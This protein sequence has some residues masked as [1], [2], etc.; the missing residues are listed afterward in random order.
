MADSACSGGDSPSTSPVQAT[1]S[2]RAG[3]RPR[4][5]AS[6][7]PHRLA[8]PASRRSFTPR[9]CVDPLV[10]LPCLI[11]PS[12]RALGT[13][14]IH[15]SDLPQPALAGAVRALRGLGG[16][17]LGRVSSAG[18]PQQGRQK[19]SAG[20]ERVG[21]PTE[22]LSGSPSRG[23]WDKRSKRTGLAFLFL[24][25]HLLLCFW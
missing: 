16:A 19:I 13:S 10:S 23:G 7:Q 18:A 5:S 6:S 8:A 14:T 11:D 25:L 20:L 21:M 3:P 9:K 4:V 22:G 1:C 15:R 12:H 2:D 24:S 17:R